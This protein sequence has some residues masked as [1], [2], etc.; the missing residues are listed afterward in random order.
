MAITITGNTELG[1]AAVHIQLNPKATYLKTNSDPSALNAVAINLAALG[2]SAGDVVEFE[3]TGDY[4]ADGAS[5][6]QTDT[7]LDMLG[8]FVREELSHA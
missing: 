8:V 4:D 2:I 7:S 3:R 5:L 6:G 1:G